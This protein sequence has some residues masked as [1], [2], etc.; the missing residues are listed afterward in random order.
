L[1]QTVIKDLE[2]FGLDLSGQYFDVLKNGKELLELSTLTELLDVVGSSL[3]T[4]D[5]V[6]T[7]SVFTKYYS[8]TVA[9]GGFYIF[10]VLRSYADL[11]LNNVQW[12]STKKWGEYRI[13]LPADGLV[14]AYN[15]SASERNGMLTSMFRHHLT[16]LYELLAQ[17]SGG[18][19][20]VYWANTAFSLYWHFR[21]WENMADSEEK[22]QLIRLD[23]EYLTQKAP[24]EIFGLRKNPLQMSFRSM[25]HPVRPSEDFIIRSQ[26][27]L[28]YQLPNTG[29]CSTCP[30]LS[31]K[32]RE[33]A[34][35]AYEGASTS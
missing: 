10:S 30:R 25:P 14:S 6:P 23:Y 18:T 16:P 15:L 8:R 4:D 13:H 3:S 33:Q 9:V 19:T 12:S 2:A 32:E 1:A 17:L 27:C 5:L 34:I 21:S 31:E 24:A 11:S 28:R 35:L 20:S 22:K 29:C 26:C 7:A